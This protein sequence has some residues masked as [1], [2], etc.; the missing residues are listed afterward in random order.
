MSHTIG[1]SSSQVRSF[2]AE[3]EGG[4]VIFFS[5]FVDRTDESRAA[6][7]ARSAVEFC[8]I[9]YFPRVTLS[10]QAEVALLIT[11]S[12]SWPPLGILLKWRQLS[13]RMENVNGD[14]SQR[15]QLFA[16]A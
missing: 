14:A 12:S 7:E 4:G 15:C 5:P 2:S 10:G 3:R 16:A 11:W 6:E 9:D 8:S 1:Q 13:E